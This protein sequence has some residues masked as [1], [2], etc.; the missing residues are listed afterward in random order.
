[1]KLY[2]SVAKELQTLYG[3]GTS[4]CWWAQACEDEKT[5]NEIAELL[6]GSSGLG[7]NIYR[8]NIGGGY[9][10]DNN[11][12]ANPWRRTESFL[13]YDRESEASFWDF[14]R[15]KNAVEMM[16]KCLALGNIDTLILFCNSPHYSQTS[17]GQASG[18]L[19]YHTCNIPKMNYKKFV[20]YVLDV[21]QHF[22]DGGLPVKYVSPINEPQ[23]KWGGSYVWQE[24]CHYETEELIEVLHLFAEEIIRRKMP[25][26]LYAP[27][28][29]E[30][31]GI[32]KEYLEAMLKD[33]AIMSVCDIFAYHSYHA[34]DRVED[35]YTFKKEFVEA[36]P[37]LRF[38][39]SEWCELPNKSHTKNFK[40]ALITARII[41]QDLAYG[42]AASWT[43][44]V[45]ANNLYINEKD[46][47]DYSDAMLSATE[48]FEKWTVN[49]RYYAMAHFSRFIP[50]G[51]KVL[52]FGFRP[53]NENNEFNVF[54]F[55]TPAGETVL[56]A[57]NE[58]PQ[59]KLSLDGDFK[60]MRVIASSQRKKLAEKYSGGFTPDLNVAANSITTIILK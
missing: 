55:K 38:D 47:F 53:T 52:D 15:D 20:S 45:A 23:W 37:E 60:T 6:Y 42:G 43:S 44:W 54:A 58:G 29:G 12:V 21:T 7:L 8:Y 49:E 59:R 36:H 33:E 18:S 10:E 50:V 1:M 56:V 16:K 26:K 17:T 39:M 57:V 48:H 25:V 9:D 11:R 2:L 40:G 3:F 30:M 13:V 22:L 14:G 51:S 41:G 28:S 35:R 5:Q 32:T 46:G 4:A 19:L 34:D 31:L 27:E 24:G